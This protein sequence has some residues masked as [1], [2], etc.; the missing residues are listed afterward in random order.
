MSKYLRDDDER[1]KDRVRKTSVDSSVHPDRK[2]EQGVPLIGDS[3]RET[4]QESARAIPTYRRTRLSG[5]AVSVYNQILMEMMTSTSR[6]ALEQ[7]PEGSSVSFVDIGGGGVKFSKNLETLRDLGVPV[8]DITVID[9]SRQKLDN[10]REN[11]YEP[12]GFQNVRYIEG[13][14]TSPDFRTETR[15]DVVNC[16]DVLEHLRDPALA[17]RR[18]HDMSDGFAIIS[19][20]NEPLFRLSTLAVALVKPDYPDRWTFI[21]RLGLDPE[22]VQTFGR[23]SFRHL[24]EDAGFEVQRDATPDQFLRR[25]ATLQLRKKGD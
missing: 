1:L 4:I 6:Q 16:V 8:G 11:G 19:S 24:A 13:D 9:I 23:R 3:S 15:G 20:P 7:K 21:K 5:R 22:H 12:R 14:V 10:A 2:V 25:W 18:I 17:M